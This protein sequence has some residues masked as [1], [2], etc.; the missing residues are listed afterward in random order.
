MKIKS[1]NTYAAFSCCSE[2]AIQIP[3]L[4][5]CR[6]YIYSQLNGESGEGRDKRQQEGRGGD[7]MKK[8]EACQAVGDENRVC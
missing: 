8:D 1:I 4:E 3:Y 7:K 6:K 5:R 2:G